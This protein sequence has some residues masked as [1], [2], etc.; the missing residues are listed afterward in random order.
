MKL[1]GI[2]VKKINPEVKA[3]MTKTLERMT[4]TRQLDT[5]QLRQRITE[6]LKWLAEE[7]QRGS[8]VRQQHTQQIVELDKQL[9]KIEGAILALESLVVDN[10]EKKA[11]V[12]KSNREKKLNQPTNRRTKPCQMP[13]EK[14]Q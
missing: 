8:T 13:P 11:K 3:R 6:K 7:R 14:T 1:K 9:L 10:E 4:Q 2:A 5:I 12:V